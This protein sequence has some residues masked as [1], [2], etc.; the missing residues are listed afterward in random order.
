MDLQAYEIHWKINVCLGGEDPFTVGKK[1]P[2][3]VDNYPSAAPW[4]KGQPPCP[5]WVRYEWRCPL[6]FHQTTGQLWNIKENIYTWSD[7]MWPPRLLYKL[8]LKPDWQTIVNLLNIINQSEIGVI[9]QCSFRLRAPRCTS[10]P[11]SGYWRGQLCKI[12]R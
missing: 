2:E 6:K 10:Y 9:N 5:Q 7:T 12:I 1:S 4:H 11:R 3:R 8:L